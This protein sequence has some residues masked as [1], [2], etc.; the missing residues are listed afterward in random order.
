MLTRFL[1]SREK[2]GMEGETRLPGALRPEEGP[3]GAAG[4]RVVVRTEKISMYSAKPRPLTP[5]AQ[6]NQE[7]EGG[8]KKVRQVTL[9]SN[10]GIMGKYVV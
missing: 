9:S 10:L 2:E 8:G 3:A 5:P 1:R 6:N 7:K 4:L